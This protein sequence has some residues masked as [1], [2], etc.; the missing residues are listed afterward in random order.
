MSWL[1]QA[2]RS[3][4]RTTFFERLRLGRAGVVEDPVAHFR[5]QI[6]ALAVLLEH[7][8]DSEGVLTDGTPARTA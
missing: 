4:M 5:R 2:T 1:M 8:D 6:Q 3:T 7:V